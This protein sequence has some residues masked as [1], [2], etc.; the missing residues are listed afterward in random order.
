MSYYPI[1]VE[2]EGRRALVVGGG[3]VAERKARTL[4]AHGARVSLVARELNPGLKELLERGAVRFLGEGFHETLLDD[5][6]IVIAATNDRELN[7]KV[8][9]AL[10]RRSAACW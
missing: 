5:I 6:F 4:L 7:R 9:R 2:L 1:L 10:P 8:T 3:E